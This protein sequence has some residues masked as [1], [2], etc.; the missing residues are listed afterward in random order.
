MTVIAWIPHYTTGHP[1]IA[2]GPGL[3]HR[4]AL[5]KAIGQASMAR[6]VGEDTY[7]FIAD[8]L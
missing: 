2:L 1:H 6:F 8:Q 3:L 7:S 4:L 5:L